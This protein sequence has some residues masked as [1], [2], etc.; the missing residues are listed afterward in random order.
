M[1]VT[2]IGS[3]DGVVL[4]TWDSPLNSHALI[5]EAL[6][7]LP[8]LCDGVPDGLVVGQR[9]AVYGVLTL[10]P[11]GSLGRRVVHV[12]VGLTDTPAPTVHP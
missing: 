5:Q 8:V 10:D 3:V 4:W 2:E 11:C 12:D 9:A 6:T 1:S 7:G